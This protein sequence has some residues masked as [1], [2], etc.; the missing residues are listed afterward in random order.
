[1]RQIILDTETTGLEWKKGNRVVEIGCVE[2]LERRPSGR[3]FHR[4]LKPDCEFEAG[5]QEVTGLTLEFLADKPAFEEIVEEFLEYID[6]AELIIHNAAF[7]LGFLDYELSRCGAHFGRITDRCSVVDT[8]LLARERFPGQRNSLDAL[9][10]RLGVD[11]SHRQ[12]HG[13]L[14]D[15][16]ILADVYI[17]L[18]SGQEE[19]GFAEVETAARG[20]AVAAVSFGPVS[21]ERPR[22]SA[23]PAE[24]EAHARRL[25]HL[26]KKAGRA[27]WDQY[28]PLP[29]PEPEL[30]PA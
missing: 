28:E 2:L 19:I 10:K 17:A 9:C 27:L 8:L 25:A 5:A 15:A 30:Q 3:N 23:Q 24:L 21:G 7:D 1:M 12:L 11:N 14:L 16:Q 13:A 18:T 29:E 22:I 26:R 6:G 4:Y 20:P